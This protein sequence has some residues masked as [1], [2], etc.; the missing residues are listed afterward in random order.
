MIAWLKRC[1]AADWTLV[2]EEKPI[3]EILH[4]ET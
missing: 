1:A 2:A 3:H 4:G